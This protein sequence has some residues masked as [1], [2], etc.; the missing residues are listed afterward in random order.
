MNIN[1]PIISFLFFL[2]IALRLTR[3]QTSF[4]S[5]LIDPAAAQS[6]VFIT[7]NQF[8]QAVTASL[9]YL[10]YPI[11][12]T[13]VMAMPI[14]NQYAYP[15]FMNY[16]VK[17]ANIT[18]MDEMAMYLAQVLYQSNGL[19]RN[20]DPA[21]AD[22]KSSNCATLNLS[23]NMYGVPVN[24]YGRGF[25]WIQGKSAYINCAQDLFGNDST[26]ITYPD[27]ILESQLINWATTSWYWNRFVQ[28]SVSSFGSTTKII[29]PSQ[30]NGSAAAPTPEL[31]AAYNIYVAILKILAPMSAPTTYY[32]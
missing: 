31:I 16:A 15:D 30:C 9:M 23:T 13:T 25:L 3:A 5:P 14:L 32:C 21:C 19:T 26:L 24:Y 20:V 10:P 8:N 17:I 18:T 29:R 27:A 1:I 11:N 4:T 22:P 7:Y 28:P 12:D 6:P 2:T